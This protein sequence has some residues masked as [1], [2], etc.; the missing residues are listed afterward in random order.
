MYKIGEETFYD[1]TLHVDPKYL[2][3]Y[4]EINPNLIDGTGRLKKELM[5]RPFTN[6]TQI[7]NDSDYT[8][9][10]RSKNITSS[11]KKDFYLARKMSGIDYPTGVVSL[12]IVF[13]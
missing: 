8:S 9:L 5:D 2:K 13:N 1:L 11:I 3:W 12:R 6:F 10:S 4:F 7:A